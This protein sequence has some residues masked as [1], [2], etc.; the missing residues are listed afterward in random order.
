MKSL[1]KFAIVLHWLL[2]VGWSLTSLFSTNTAISETVLASFKKHLRKLG[3]IISL[4]PLFSF[5]ATTSSS[6]AT[7]RDS[8]SALAVDC[9]RT[10]YGLSASIVLV[11]GQ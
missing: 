3:H 5:T 1:S 8:D 6:L 2:L 10:L 7:A 4:V 9:I 11:H